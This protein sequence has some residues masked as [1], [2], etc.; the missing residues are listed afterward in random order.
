MFFTFNQKFEAFYKIRQCRDNYKKR[1]PR[2]TQIH[3]CKNKQK[4]KVTC[5]HG[6][7][8]GI[9]LQSLCQ[10]WHIDKRQPEYHL[11]F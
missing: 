6:R 11:P 2:P 10:R 9:V 1:R 7:C 8:T 5:Q 4:K 3:V